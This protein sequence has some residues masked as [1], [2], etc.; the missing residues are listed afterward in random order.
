MRADDE[1]VFRQNMFQVGEHHA[2]DDQGGEHHA[3]DDD[4]KDDDDDD[5]GNPSMDKF[6]RFDKTSIWVLKGFSGQHVCTFKSLKHQ[7]NQLAL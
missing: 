2:D 5:G 6:L 4:D 1:E 7:S 3:D